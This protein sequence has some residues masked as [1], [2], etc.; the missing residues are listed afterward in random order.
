MHRKRGP[1]PDTASH[2][3]VVRIVAAYGDTW[4]SDETW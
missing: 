3:K 1:K 4:T 2:E